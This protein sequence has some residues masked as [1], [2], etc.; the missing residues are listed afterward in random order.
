MLKLIFITAVLSLM[1]S[2]MVCMYA[3]LVMDGEAQKWEE[4]DAD[5]QATT[6]DD[7]KE[8]TGR[9]EIL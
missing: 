9:D 4:W 7:G 3:V 6:S 5:E 8:E 2:F 1:A